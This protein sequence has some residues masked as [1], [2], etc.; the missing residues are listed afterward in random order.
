M[1]EEAGRMQKKLFIP[2]P[3]DVREDVLAQMTKPIIG[4]RTKAASDLQ[5]NISEKLQKIFYANNQ[6]ILSTSSGTAM[7][8]GAIRS[9]TKKRAAVFSNGFFGNLW[10]QMALH[11]NLE[12]DLFNSEKGEAITAEMVEKVLSSGKYDLITITHNETSSG[13][14]NP[15]E[16]LSRVI[17]NYPEVIWCV[18]GVSSVGGI[19]L[20]IDKLGI[21]VCI[22][23]SQKCLGLPPG[24][25]IA[26]VSEKAIERARQVEFR[27]Y[28]LDFLE[29]YETIKRTDY[30]YISTPAIPMMFAMDYQ[31]DRILDEG[32][33]NR[34][35]RHREL[36]NMVRSWAK[37][38]FKLYAKGSCASNTVTTIKNTLDLDIDLLN[39]KL[40]ERGFQ[41]S[42]GYGELK[43]KT[44]RIGHMADCREE[45][46]QEL[47]DTLDELLGFDVVEGK[48]A[49]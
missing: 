22:V 45:D 39:K 3:V 46:L 33:E 8:E 21:D 20:E 48:I 40:G 34:F 30:Q 7:M 44:F 13:I 23:S 11:N 15:L 4:H 9:F 1:K 32:L 38:H 41:I 29:L 12:A 25:A 17:N 31:L 19:K 28:Y 2:G 5:R 42:N 14:T 47:L 10:Y 24:M 16:E 6:I 49:I 35:E 27:G 37:K 26:S 18:D 36:G 43:D